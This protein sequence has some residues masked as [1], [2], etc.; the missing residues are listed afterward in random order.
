L[1]RYAANWKSVLYSGRHLAKYDIVYFMTVNIIDGFKAVQV[2][3]H[4]AYIML[5]PLS[6]CEDVSSV[7]EQQCTIRETGERIM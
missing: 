6:A 1:S 4:H 5:C 7:L 3:E 2:N